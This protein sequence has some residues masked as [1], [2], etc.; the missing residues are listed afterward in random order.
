MISVTLL[1][2]A[3]CI[4]YPLSAL[5]REEKKS[6]KATDLCVAAQKG[7]QEVCKHLWNTKNVPLT[8]QDRDGKTALMHALAAGH[9]ELAREL[10]EADTEGASLELQDK[11]GKTAREHALAWQAPNYID[12]LIIEQLVVKLDAHIKQTKKPSS[13]KETEEAKR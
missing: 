8:T 3:S 1:I 11:S 5:H 2:L 6:Y 12:K 13:E 7:Y 4:S 10:I 9:L